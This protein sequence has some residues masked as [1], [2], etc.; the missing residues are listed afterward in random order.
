M[1]SLFD[2]RGRDEEDKV[3]LFQGEFSG[4]APERLRGTILKQEEHYAT[5]KL[6]GVDLSPIVT[7]KRGTRIAMDME[8]HFETRVPGKFN[9]PVILGKGKPIIFPT[10]R[11]PCRRSHT[12]TSQHCYAPWLYKTQSRALS[13][14]DI[15]CAPPALSL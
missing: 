2:A 6:I 14:K 7:H 5:L 3:F 15:M 10:S 1:R 13:K 8:V 9:E 12:A 11:H 4:Y